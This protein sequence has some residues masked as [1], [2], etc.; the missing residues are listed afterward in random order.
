MAD[1]KCLFDL[2]HHIHITCVV[3]MFLYGITDLFLFMPC[4]LCIMLVVQLLDSHME[5]NRDVNGCLIDNGSRFL[6]VSL[7]NL[8][9]I[10]FFIFCYDSKAHGNWN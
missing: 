8:L 3:F 6:C 9:C 4:V 10:I 5:C 7:A 2:A 1:F